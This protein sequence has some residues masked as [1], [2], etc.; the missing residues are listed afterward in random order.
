M[1][2]SGF[3]IRKVVALSSTKPDA[4][5]EFAAGL[6]V[7]AGAS[8]TGKTYAWQLIDFLL[9]ASNPP[10]TV[11]LDSTYS[12][13]MFELVSRAGAVT[14]VSRA[15]AGG[16]AS[17]FALPIDQIESGTPVTVLAEKHEGGNQQTI[18]GLLLG[19]AGLWGKEIRKNEYGVKR[20]LSF[21][22]VAWLSLVDE[23]RII[24]ER[25]PALSEQYTTGTEEKSAF[26][27]LLTGVDDAA[28]VPQERPKDRKQRI[29]TEMTILQ[30]L[31]DDRQSR[32]SGYQVEDDQLPAQR[33]RLA[34][35]IAEATSLLAT[36][37]SELD[38]AAGTRDAAWSELQEIDSHRLFLSEQV[39]RLELLREH[40]QSDAA[41]LESSLE[42]GELMER[43]PQGECPVCGHVPDEAKAEQPD[44][45]QLREF[46]TA[47]RAELAKIATS[48]RDLELSLTAMRAEDD[49]LA[50]RRRQSQ[51]SL[52]Q[53]N[54]TIADLLN[55]KMKSADQ[56]LSQL[57]AQQARLSEAAFTANEVRDLRTRFVAVE[58]LSK[59]KVAK[60][61]LA[62]KVESAGMAEFCKVVETTLRAWKFPFTGNVSWSDDKFDLVIGSENRGGMGKGFRAVT[63]AAFT[64]ALMRYCRLKNL[65]HP[66]VVVLDTPLNPYKG[67]DKTAKEEANM[68]LQEAFYADLAQDKSGDQVIVFENTEPP[69]SVRRKMR[70]THF[71]GNVAAKPY[72]FFPVI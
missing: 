42:A 59:V 36:Q 5:L 49:S 55:T 33:T 44:D 9:G 66:G 46:Q 22:D 41:R 63:H 16:P 13:A 56:Q 28:I 65:P 19:L 12:Q 64:V 25:S 52:N 30:G 72:G 60:P 6:N 34:A 51:E 31:L 67:A 69:V 11:P 43:L 4:M 29:E 50:A 45:T 27:L 54:S 32:L 23:E 17:A 70:Y 61:K 15:L 14:T 26:G 39:K 20:S 7:V 40:Y 62:K 21:R 35:A 8:N 37:Q 47:C 58:Q 48:A 3:T 24:T 10:K 38:R 57:L 71:S 53:A 18:S 2:L 68:E 1:D